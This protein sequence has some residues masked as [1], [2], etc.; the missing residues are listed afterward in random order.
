[1]KSFKE[2]INP[3]TIINIIVILLLILGTTVHK[4]IGKLFLEKASVFSVKTVLT[5]GISS[6]PQESNKAETEESI[7][8][9][10][11]EPTTQ[12]LKQAEEET[13]Q[14]K[15]KSNKDEKQNETKKQNEDD[16]DFTA[17]PKDIQKQIEAY[18]KTSKSDKKGGDISEA[19]YSTSG[20]TDKY[21]LVRIKNVNDTK[22]NVK[23]IL[24][25]QK[26]DIEIKDKSQPTVLIYHTHT[27]EC[28]QVLDRDYYAKGFSSRNIN[29]E[30]NIVRVGEEISEELEKMGFCV[31]HDTN[32]YD[33][34][35]SGAYY[36]SEEKAEEYL[37]KYPS[38]QVVLDIHR[39]AIE[40]SDG[41][42]VKPTATI[43]G[44]KC[45]QMMIIAGCQEEG[46]GI[47]NFE[48][49]RQNLTFA[50]HLQEQLEKQF[51]GITRPTY[52]CPR[53]YN[54]NQSHCG[55]L[56]EVG[57]DA[58]T[59]EEAVYAGKCLGNALGNLMEKYVK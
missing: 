43:K 54:M 2:K 35:Y 30:E 51:E 16:E 19:H 58:N 12:N 50:V 38:I 32:I 34:K 5:K 9:T 25:N 45:A 3:I 22:I 17:T 41:T 31:L 1:M 40:Y 36:R 42:K 37:K 53:V 26:P 11:A 7:V 24:E 13:T 28:F 4:D 56:I 52:F 59:L 27:T 33:S 46:N 44:K 10:S 47:T 49:W 21:S 55:L 57:S 14:S 29:I 48:D 8:Q 20:V 6:V 23:D 18:K 15:T 39:D